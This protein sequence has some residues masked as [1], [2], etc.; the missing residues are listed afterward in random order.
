MDGVGETV[1]LV[2]V[3]FVEEFQE[4]PPHDIV[5]RDHRLE[6]AEHLGRQPHRGCDDIEY[7]LVGNG[8]LVQLHD[9]KTN[10]LL[11]NVACLRMQR[12][13]ADIGQV[14][15]RT[16]IGDDPALL[17]DRCDHGDVGQMAGSDLRIVGGEHVTFPKRLG[18]KLRQEIFLRRDRQRRDEH[19]YGPRALGERPATAVQQNGHIIVVLAHDRR[20]GRAPENIVGL[21]SNED[22]AIPHHLEI[23]RII[24]VGSVFQHG[25]SSSNNVDHEI[26]VSVHISGAARTDDCRRL[27]LLDDGRA[28]H[29]L[30]DWQLVVIVDRRFHVGA[31]FVEIDRSPALEGGGNLDL[32]WAGDLVLAAAGTKPPGDDLDGSRYGTAEQLAVELGEIIQQLPEKFI[33]HETAI[34]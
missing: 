11:E 6:V 31:W 15:D 34:G 17:E 7:V 13:S 4:L 19:R 25:A 3:I 2:E 1:D 23:D 16:G 24:E 14:R 9:W 12:P 21:I 30:I 29:R 18:W 28:P 26:A 32:M 27:A 10:T 5:R 22:Q 8:G 20:E 33:L